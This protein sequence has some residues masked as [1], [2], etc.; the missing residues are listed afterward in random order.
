[1]SEFAAGFEE[2]HSEPARSSF[3][4]RAPVIPI[5]PSGRGISL[6]P[7]SVNPFALLLRTALSTDFAKDPGLS[8]G[9]ADWRHFQLFQQNN[10]SQRRKGCGCQGARLRQ[11]RRLAVRVWATCFDNVGQKWKGEDGD[12]DEGNNEEEDAEDGDADD[13]DEQLPWETDAEIGCVILRII[14]VD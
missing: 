8:V 12:D 11:G 10:L 1:M 9:A 3:R 5:P 7:L 2:C 6:W 13:D 14:R 4:A